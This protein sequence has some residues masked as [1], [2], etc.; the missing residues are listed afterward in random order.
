MNSKIENTA[1]ANQM[2]HIV[3]IYQ[4]RY[5]ALFNISMK[6]AKDDV[7]FIYRVNH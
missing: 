5:P 7:K 1:S 4:N 6:E 3:S 2:N